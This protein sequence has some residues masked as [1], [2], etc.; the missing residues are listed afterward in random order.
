MTDDVPHL[1]APTG[2]G[3]AISTGAVKDSW[4]CGF[5]RHLA[6]Q[7]PGRP[8][9]NLAVNWPAATNAVDPPKATSVA[10]TVASASVRERDN[11][12]RR[13]DRP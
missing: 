13:V 7:G 3:S 1:E 10:A 5:Q 9:G 6:E 2:I 11:D 4:W 12:E 8:N